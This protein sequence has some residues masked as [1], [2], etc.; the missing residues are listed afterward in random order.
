MGNPKIGCPE[1]KEE[2][3]NIVLSVGPNIFGKEVGAIVK[4]LVCV[5]CGSKQTKFVRTATKNENQ[6][7]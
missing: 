5:Y 1:H 7:L 6:V 4:H 3:I 2:L